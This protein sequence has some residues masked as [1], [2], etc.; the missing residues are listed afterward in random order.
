MKP[1]KRFVG[2]FLPLITG[3]KPGVNEMSISRT[4]EAKLETRARCY[5]FFL[6]SG[7]AELAAK[8]L[9]TS[10]FCIGGA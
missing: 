7:H 6:T 3:L 8:A 10:N 1:L 5:L 4:F 9:A 2:S